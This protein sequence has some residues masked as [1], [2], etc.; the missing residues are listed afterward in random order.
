MGTDDRHGQFEQIVARLTTDYP[1]LA[2]RR[3]WSR[4]ALITAAVV[5]GLGWGLLSVSMVAWGAAGVVLTCSVV[6]VV[7]AAIFLDGHR[8]R[9]SVSLGPAAQR[10]AGRPG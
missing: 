3:H 2:G 10:K 8:L 6:A 5:G 7:G 9:R 4:R 1:S